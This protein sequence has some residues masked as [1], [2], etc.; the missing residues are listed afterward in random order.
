MPGNFNSEPIK[1][2]FLEQIPRSMLDDLA[3]E[4]HL[5]LSQHHAHKMIDLPEQHVFDSASKFC[6]VVAADEVHVLHLLACM[7]RYNLTQYS[8]VNR[9]YAQ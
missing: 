7:V 8:R 5:D 2:S 3:L 9:H 6:R 4:T 1:P